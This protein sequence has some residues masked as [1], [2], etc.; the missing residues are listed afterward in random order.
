[1]KKIKYDLDDFAVF[2]IT[3]GRP[4]NVLTY[5]TIKKHGY[6]GP[7]YLIVDDLDKAQNEYIEN[8]GDEVRIFDK[9]A[10]SKTIDNGNN[11]KELRTTTHARNACFD[12]AKELEIKYFIVF[13]DDYTRFAYRFDTTL[14]YC[15]KKM[16][17]LDDVLSILL[18]FY[19]KTPFDTIAMAQGGE[20][21]AGPNGGFG[22]KVK[23]KRKC[24]NSFICST[25]RPFKFFSTL[26]EDVNT[27]VRLGSTGVLFGTFNHVFLEQVP[28]QSGESG[29][30]DVYLK[31][32]TYVKSFYSVMYHPSSVK[33]WMLPS[34]NKRLHHLIDWKKTVPKIIPEKYKKRY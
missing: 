2:I 25:E 10:I 21:I 32:G 30:T 17:K 5:K 16:T 20:F 6:T 29:M 22:K 9:I 3:H 18:N 12:V 4:N 23:M 15:S 34:K 33:V 24:M 13:D 28:T 19:K 1:M 14:T 7:I 8:Y 27:P 11:F 26:N 31:F